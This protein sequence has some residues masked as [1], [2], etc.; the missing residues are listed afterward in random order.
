MD[1]RVLIP[2]PETE[3]LAGEVLAWAAGRV[4]RAML[5][6]WVGDQKALVM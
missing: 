5:V 1:R 4:A 6:L 2:R 3:L